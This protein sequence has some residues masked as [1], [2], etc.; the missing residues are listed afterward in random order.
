MSGRL[1]YYERYVEIPHSNKY[2]VIKTL[3]YIEPNTCFPSSSVPT[4]IMV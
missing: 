3:K 2:R 4:K 1:F